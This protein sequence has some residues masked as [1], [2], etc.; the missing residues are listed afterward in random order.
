MGI[1][2]ELLKDAEEDAREVEF[3]RNHL[4][5]EVKEKFT[6]EEIYYFLDV[7][8]D[9][10]ASSDAFDGEPDADGYVE[11]DLDK[12]T[13][14][15]VRKARQEKMGE[16]DPDDVFFVVQGEMEYSQQFEDEE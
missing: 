15:V 10:Y 11:I 16:F 1:D 2:E 9:Y 13:D 7:I 12:V 4:P 6:E 8:I 14:H 3:I 5:Q